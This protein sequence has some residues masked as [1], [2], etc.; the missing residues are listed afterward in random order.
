MYKISKKDNAVTVNKKKSDV[1]KTLS[2]TMSDMWDNTY[3]YVD[4]LAEKDD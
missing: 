3:D 1:N 2:L 4:C